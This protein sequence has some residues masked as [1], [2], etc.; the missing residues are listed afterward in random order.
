VL[1][2]QLVHDLVDQLRGSVAVASAGGT[3]FTVTFGFE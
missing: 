3:S 1:G 2:L